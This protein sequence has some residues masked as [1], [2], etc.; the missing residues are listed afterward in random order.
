MGP[1]PPPGEDQEDPA[2]SGLAEADDVSYDR[3]HDVALPLDFSSQF[4]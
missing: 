3:S 2:N 1:E 4:P